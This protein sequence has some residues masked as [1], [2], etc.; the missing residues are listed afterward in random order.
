MK[1][2]YQHI[3]HY[4][5][6]SEKYRQCEIIRTNVIRL[7]IWEGQMASNTQP[8][9]ISHAWNQLFINRCPFVDSLNGEEVVK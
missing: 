5:Y 3:M 1:D 6:I 8:E 9:H 7:S 4:V 2:M